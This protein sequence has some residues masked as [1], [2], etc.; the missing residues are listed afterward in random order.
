MLF[1]KK[2][3]YYCYFVFLIGIFLLVATIF[4]KN[5]HAFTKSENLDYIIDEIYIT[6]EMNVRKIEVF[7]YLF[8]V[9]T[10]QEKEF[11]LIRGIVNE[12]QE[13]EKVEQYFISRAPS[14]YKLIYDINSMY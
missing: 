14:S 8:N 2:K 4:I 7:G 6:D 11:I 13:I 9:Y 3:K 10:N 5:S 12:W 1:K